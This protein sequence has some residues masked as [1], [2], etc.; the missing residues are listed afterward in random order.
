MVEHRLRHNT[1]VLCSLLLLALVYTVLLYFFR[2]L[3][4]DDIADGVIG[5][6]LGLYVCSHPAANAVDLLFF[7]RDALREAASGWSGIGWLGLNLLVTLVGWFAIF[8]GALR[9]TGRE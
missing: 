3:T 8:I 4:G 7:H 1:T 2:T 5:V 6:L 9:F